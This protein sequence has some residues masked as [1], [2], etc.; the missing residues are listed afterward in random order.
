MPAA[1]ATKPRARS[2]LPEDRIGSLR[3]LLSSRTRP[4][5]LLE[6]HSALTGLVAEHARALSG[7]GHVESFDGMWSSSLTASALCG[8]PDIEAMDTTARLRIVDDT[9]AVTTAPMLYD[10]DTGSLPELFKFTVRSLE[11]RG[12]SGCIIEDKR[13]LKQNSL[14]GTDRSQMLED[15]PSFC[16][17]ITA[18]REARRTAEFMVIARVEALIAGAGMEEAILRA[19]AYTDAGADAIMIHSH[20]SSPSEV[21]SFVSQ[22][23]M[24]LGDSAVPIVVAPSSY[25]SVHE[26]ELQRAGVAVVIYANHLLRA[27]FPAMLAAAKS[28]LAHGRCAEADAGLMPIKEILSVIDEDP[29][30]ERGEQGR[31]PV[32][33]LDPP[34]RTLASL[35]NGQETPLAKLSSSTAGLDPHSLLHLL[36]SVLDVRMFSG[37]PDSCLASFCA[38][39]DSAD[40]TLGCTH[41][42]TADE[43]GA[44]GTALGYYLATN[45]VPLVYMQNSGL[46]NAVNPLISAAHMEVYGCPLIL[47]I[48]WR[49]APGTED[50][51][52]HR[53]QGRQTLAMLQSLEIETFQLPRDEEGACE[54]VSRAHQT[55]LSSHSPVALLAPPATFN[56]TK[57]IHHAHLPSEL[58]T[59]EEAIRGV[60]AHIGR[61]DAVVATTGYTSRE[62]YE[63]RS[64]L[65]ES[66]EQDFL[67]V[68]S[69]G[70]AI[71]IAQGIAIAQPARR[72]WCLDGDGSALMHLGSMAVSSSRK[73]H[74][75]R[76][77]LLNNSVHDSVGGQPTAASQGT[78][79]ET[80]GDATLN[81]SALARAIGY[82][83][84][85]C[86]SSLEEL[87]TAFS[88]T[89]QDGPCFVEI[90]L[91]LGT[92]ADLGRPKTSTAEAKS[93]FMRFLEVA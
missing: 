53:V 41:V 84:V 19:T 66:H 31:S 3:R 67:T 89:N 91:K 45:K 58:P 17:K 52:Q 32:F 65:G 8:K 78:N 9:L 75:L 73:L 28:I 23:R 7:R 74:N 4:L 51:P 2:G 76:H 81:F 12:V 1:P 48:G 44:V 82:R 10:A 30:S 68:G 14:F 54:V 24:A 15:I 43:G 20:L 36:C 87:A 38:A 21:L 77:V 88:S 59:R 35:A 5:R 61:T 79:G 22:Y 29:G 50:E 33:S 90:K 46:G 55:A 34:S 6:T 40:P 13:G 62:L 37:V 86:V 25:S 11:Q 92:R 85:S 39:L 80:E 16:A 18:G 27:A 49:G 70:H 72:V 60:R 93:A 42:I 83:T 64:A 47:L 63:L 56:R 69:M 26:E 57:P 71:A